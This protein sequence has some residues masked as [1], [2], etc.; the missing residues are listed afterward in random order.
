MSIFLATKLVPQINLHLLR[1]DFFDGISLLLQD[2]DG[3]PFDLSAVEVCAS[4]WKYQTSGVLSQITAFNIEKQEPLRNGVI[5]L[6]LS[7]SQVAA[8]WDAAE[9]PQNAAISQSFFP[10]TYTENEVQGS[11]SWDVRIE[12]QDELADLI[13]VSSGVFIS[14]TNH[15]LGATERVVF[16]GTTT[17]SGINYNGTSAR[18][19]TNLTGITYLA[20]YSFTIASLSGI[21]AS[22]IGGKVYRLKQDTVVGGGVL[23]GTTFSNCFP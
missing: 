10:T 20:P 11:L 3:E 5:K 15:G 2:S 22:G 18:I 16:S 21:T 8:I 7:S 23:V 12:K 9:E 13:S 14:Q 6:W 17:S 4:V 1:R 19:Y